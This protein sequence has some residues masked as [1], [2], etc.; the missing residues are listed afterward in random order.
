MTSKISREEVQ[1]AVA[2]AMELRA[3]HAALLHGSTSSPTVPRLLAG[4]SPSLASAPGHFSAEDYPV[5]TPSYGEESS[6]WRGIRMAEGEEWYEQDLEFT[7]N[8][9]L[10]KSSFLRE[11]EQQ[12]HTCSEEDRKSTKSLCI[13]H[14][15]L[16]QSTPGTDVLPNCRRRGSDDHKLVTSGDKCKTEN[17]NG[18]NESDG[19]IVK[20]GNAKEVASSD[21]KT[22]GLVLSWFLPRGRRKPKL[23]MSPNKMESGD[24]SQLLK[25]WG[26]FSVES[27]KK[28][29]LEANA[30]KDAALTQVSEMRSTLIELKQKLVSL[31]TYCEELKKAL[32]Q[33]SQ[34]KG[35]QILDRPKLSKRSKSSNDSR[36]NS[37]PVSHEVMVEGFLQIVSEARLSVKQFCRILINLIKE[38]DTNLV[39]KLSSQLKTTS[40]CKHSKGM[41][42]HLEALV[43][44]SLYQDF[45]NCMFDKNGTPK[46]LDPY[47]D[48]IENF[49]A[50]VALRNL[51]SNEVLK[52]GSKCYSEDFSRFCDRKMSGIAS[53]LNWSRPWPEHLL[54]S[55]FVSAKCI[56]L[57]HLL[58]FSFSPPLMI[59]RVEENRSF[60][61]LYM[62]DVLHDKHRQAHTSACVKIMVMPGFYV[63]DRVLRCR[64][65]CK[66]NSMT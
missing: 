65:L 8:G 32:K 47:Q 45:E 36:D 50:F 41:L 37:M 38:T 42:Y 1:A 58:A 17:I 7:N 35:T 21:I 23:E 43:N 10:N 14:L 12:Q 57:L 18:E 60:D 39:E 46:V 22:R 20:N 33:A 15:S 2:K 34:A 62:E 6:N 44:L 30:N 16:S 28:E 55:F 53:I 27:L 56:W 61:P 66:H 64:V 54:Q 51:S 3:L 9:A 29:V 13:S 31:E 52:K 5:F 40:N 48:R 24:V 11:A 63:E 19:K 59:L 26:V 49:S 4:S 25:S